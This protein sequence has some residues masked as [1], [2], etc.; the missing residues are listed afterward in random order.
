V[1]E[2]PARVVGDTLLF[3]P[4][5]PRAKYPVPVTVV[6]WQYGRQTGDQIQSAVP[7]TRQFYITRP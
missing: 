1:L 5:P 7:I 4:V 2:G 3:T 6:A